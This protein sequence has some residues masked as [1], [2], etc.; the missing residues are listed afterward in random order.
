MKIENKTDW[1]ARAKMIDASIVA[2]SN[3]HA[4][5]MKRMKEAQKQQKKESGKK[6]R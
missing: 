1:Q 2:F 6:A 4:E 5:A 3:A